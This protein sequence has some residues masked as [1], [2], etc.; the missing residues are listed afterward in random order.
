MEQKDSPEINPKY[1]CEFVVNHLC[2]MIYRIPTTGQGSN[3]RGI[4]NMGVEE[5]STLVSIAHD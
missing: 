5:I 1:K 2:C 4:R 3:V